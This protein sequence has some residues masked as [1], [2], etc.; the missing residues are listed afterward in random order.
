MAK[1]IRKTKTPSEL[2]LE[3]Q[4]PEEVESIPTPQGKDFKAPKALAGAMGAVPAGA[5]G[6]PLNPA[7]KAMGTLAKAAGPVALLAPIAIRGGVA[8]IQEM[9][10]AARA[11]RQQYKTDVNN[12]KTGQLGLSQAKQGQMAASA[13]RQARSSQVAASANAASA[14]AAGAPG[15]GASGQLAALKEGAVSDAALGQLTG[16]I[17][18]VSGKLASSEGARVRAEMQAKKAKR[19]QTVSDI[20]G[21]SST[22][23]GA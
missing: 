7:L 18:E 21:I 9:G 16:Q 5:I 19:A 13:L 20:L 23:K 4:P 2:L 10:P 1:T 12:L 14:L 11:E 17:A 3:E 6:G 8:A 22:K 15:G